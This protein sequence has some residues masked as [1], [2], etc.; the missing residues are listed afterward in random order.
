LRRSARSPPAR[1]GNR[2]Y[3][4]ALGI[5]VDEIDITEEDDLDARRLFGLNEDVRMG[6]TDVRLAITITGPEIGE[7]YEELRNFVDAHCP[8]LDLLL[9]PTP[10]S[11]SVGKA[12][13]ITAR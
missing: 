7:R 3:A 5:H 11:V 2:L 8:L 10:V 12:R 1:A 9:N 13:I 4:Q 6:F